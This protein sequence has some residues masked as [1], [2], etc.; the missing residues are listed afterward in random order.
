MPKEKLVVSIADQYK[1]LEQFIEH[2]H[3]LS[4]MNK[5][6]FEV[7]VHYFRRWHSMGGPVYEKPIQISLVGMFQLQLPINTGR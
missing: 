6:Q 2:R 7:R 1:S 4:E 5:V 3:R